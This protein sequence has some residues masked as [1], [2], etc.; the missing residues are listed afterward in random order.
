MNF[1]S[2][3]SLLRGSALVILASAALYGCKDF[4]Q[5]AAEPQGA[6]IASTIATKAGVEGAR[7]QIHAP[8][9]QLSKA[10]IVR[11]AVELD[12]DLSLTHSCYDPVDGRACGQCD[13]CLLRRKGFLEAG[14]ADPVGGL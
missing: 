12:V 4:L 1:T 2:K 5:N 11:K 14:V 7:I 10:D 3:N 8:L 6:V 13:S 9:I